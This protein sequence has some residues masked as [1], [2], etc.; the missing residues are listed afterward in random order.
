VE[1]PE[2]FGIVVPTDRGT[3]ADIEEKPENPKSNLATT[4][5]YVLDDSLF[6]YEPMEH[7]DGEY[8]L[9]PVIVQMAREKD[10]FIEREG[11]WIA[12]GYPGDLQKAEAILSG[13]KTGVE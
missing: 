10:I 5:A 8:Y 2:R 3:V 9:P 1:H 7:G 11:S 12:I 4:M 13:Q 6:E